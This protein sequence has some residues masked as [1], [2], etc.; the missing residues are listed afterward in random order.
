MRRTWTWTLAAA[1]VLVGMANLMDLALAKDSIA[2]GKNQ[3]RNLLVN[4]N[5]ERTTP[6]RRLDGA[7]P[8]TLPGFEGK[9]FLPNGWAVLPNHDGAGIISVVQ[10]E[11]GSALRVQ[12]KRGESVTLRQQAEVVPEAAYACGVSIKG[13][14]TV[15]LRVTDQLPAPWQSWGPAS[16]Q[17]AE[18]WTK[19]GLPLTVGVHRHFAAL[20]ID[21]GENADVLLRDAEFAHRWAR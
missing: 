19:V 14:G 16:A 20:W 2:E 8:R 17:A 18:A 12:T 21:I 4:P 13:K 7:F 15:S 1:V 6:G 3:L 9:A 5:F 11:G 10:S